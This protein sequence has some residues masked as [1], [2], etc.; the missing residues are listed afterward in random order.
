MRTWEFRPSLLSLLR[1]LRDQIYSNL[2]SESQTVYLPLSVDVADLDRY[3]KDASCSVEEPASDHFPPDQLSP[4]PGTLSVG[5]YR[6]FRDVE[7]PWRVSVRH[8]PSDVSRT[9]ESWHQLHAM[10]VRKAAAN[11]IALMQTSRHVYE[12]AAPMLYSLC[13]FVF[14]FDAPLKINFHPSIFQRIQTIYIHVDLIK[15]YRRH[16]SDETEEETFESFRLSLRKLSSLTDVTP[17][18]VIAPSGLILRR[19]TEKVQVTSQITSGH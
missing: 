11:S 13:I 4:V 19:D 5:A 3:I 2:L 15:A 8:A 7:K 1:E 9:L 16:W 18:F 14:P 10:T 12:E 17:I 6:S